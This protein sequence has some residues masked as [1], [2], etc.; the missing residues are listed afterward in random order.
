[1]VRI[2]RLLSWLAGAVAL[3]AV[4][5]VSPY[6]DRPLLALAL[7]ATVAGPWCDRRQRYP[8][9]RLAA[10]LLAGAGILFYAVQI[11]T[12]DVATPVVHAMLILLVVR[13]LSP[14]Q[15][16]DYLQIFVLGL[17]ILAG[18]SL[19]NLSIG[20]IFALVLL[21]FAVTVG[22]VLLTFHVTDPQ[23]RMP[24]QDLAKLLRVTLLLPLVSL[25]L[26]MVFFTVLPRTRHP[27]W[28]FLNPGGQASA[29][30]AEVV[31]PGAF[32]QLSASG[33]L[34]F[35]AET[36][37]LPREQLYWRVLVLNQPQGSQ[38]IRVEPPEGGPV[39]VEGGRLLNLVIYPEPQQSRQLITLDR[40]VMVSGVR[41]QTAPD[42]VVVARR[43]LDRRTSFEVT[44]R[45]D[46][47]LAVLGKPHR[48]FYLVPPTN[49]SPRV[50]ALAA[51]M[52]EGTVGAEA[53][54][55]AL[56]EFFRNQQLIYAENDLPGGPD[57]VDSFLFEKRRG[58]CE[59]FASSYVTL[60]RLLGIPA[61]LVGGY[62][63]GDYNGLG[64]YYRVTENAA[65]VWV[66][67]LSD[68]NRWRRVDPSQWASNA[69]SALGE[70]RATLL[71]RLQ[72]LADTFNY[73]WI[74]AV[75]I[76]DFERQIKI[77]SET[78]ADL[79]DLRPQRIPPGVW[80]ILAISVFTASWFVLLRKRRRLSPEARLIE[81]LRRRLGRRHGPDTV[82]DTLGL[83]ELAA[84][85]DSEACR[86]FARIYL[87]A[88]FRDRAL[89]NEEIRKLRT[90]IRDI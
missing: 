80:V 86:E 38:W 85:T 31:Q 11:T 72:H 22:L 12:L 54:L 42:Q 87:A 48:E 27:L 47:T 7:L 73:Y 15:A 71:A 68:E 83:N 55:Q 3:F 6:L 36:E 70:R 18:S 14:K 30:L 46:A 24:R 28:N 41:H 19:L 61:R 51:E 26:M 5:P 20:F 69:S 90:L 82:P 88:A 66:E 60:A 84:R 49:V 59:F 34:A 4:I 37:A 79:R 65:H 21:V 9:N 89:T 50:R 13:L 62:L 25:L 56:A 8:L 17:F 32:A 44:A 64:G 78:G 76:F 43:A 53:R 81:D 1:M 40:P 75:V 63:G 23:L 74:Q 58:Y 10:T 67:V 35:R 2:E 77:F 33:Q 45:T 29:G 57:P 16:R 52:A 39:R